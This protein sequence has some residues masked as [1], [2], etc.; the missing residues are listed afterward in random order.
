MA[1]N[2]YTQAIE[3]ITTK[4]DYVFIYTID[5]HLIYKDEC[6]L[7]PC[8]KRTNLPPK[9]VTGD[10]NVT[11]QQG[12]T[13]DKHVTSPQRDKSDISVTGPISKNIQRIHHTSGPDRA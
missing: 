10:T 9:K 11:C 7:P 6:L 13:C 2:N 5:I 8:R 3:P 12:A 1:T 4:T